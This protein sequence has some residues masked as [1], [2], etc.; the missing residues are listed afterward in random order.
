MDG[1]VI[2]PRCCATR[3]GCSSFVAQPDLHARWSYGTGDSDRGDSLETF[4]P[5]SDRIRCSVARSTRLPPAGGSCTQPRTSSLI[6]SP[7]GRSPTLA[8]LGDAPWPIGWSLASVPPA[9]I[10]NF[11]AERPCRTSPDGRAGVPDRSFDQRHSEFPGALTHANCNRAR[12]HCPRRPQPAGRR[13]CIQA[14]SNEGVR[15]RRVRS[16]SGVCPNLPPDSGVRVVRDSPVQGGDV[17]SHL[18]TGGRDR[19][20]NGFVSDAL[21]DRWPCLHHQ[22]S[23]QGV[24]RNAQ[25]V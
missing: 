12:P 23:E 10:R 7:G 25:A 19:D 11:G 20:G 17:Y 2:S 8:R 5:H 9:T 22:S 18:L 24:A 16:S 6:P 13:F 1:Q 3:C 14:H 4:R 21:V 15:Y